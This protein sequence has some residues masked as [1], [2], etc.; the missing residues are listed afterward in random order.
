MRKNYSELDH[1]DK[2]MEGNTIKKQKRVWEPQH[3]E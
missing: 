2:N 3:W 1:Y